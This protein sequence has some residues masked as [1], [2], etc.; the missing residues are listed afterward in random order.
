MRPEMEEE[1]SDGGRAPLSCARNV[2][3]RRYGKMCSKQENQM[4]RVN[5]EATLVGI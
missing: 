5:L 3:N 4:D 1:S 2:V